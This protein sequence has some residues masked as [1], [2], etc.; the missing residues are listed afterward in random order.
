MVTK[1]FFRKVEEIYRE[2]EVELTSL[3]D[4][5]KNMIVLAERS[6]MKIDHSI[7]II[8]EM[9]K[10]VTFDSIADEICFFK[11]HK[12]LFVSK[13]IYYSKLL[14]IESNKPYAGIKAQRKYYENELLRIKKYYSGE[15]EFYN[16]YRRNAT[17]LDY[18]YFIRKAHDLKMKLSSNLYNFD[19]SFTTTH[20]HKIAVFVAYESL[21]KYL[22]H[23]LT[24]S[25]GNRVSEGSSQI[26]WTSSKVSLLELLYALHLSHC[27]NGGNIDF[28]EI[29]RHTEKTLDLNLGNVYKTIREIKNRKYK[30]N[31]FLELLNDNLEKIFEEDDH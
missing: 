31:R 1:A 24:D 4:N 6:L 18:K 3:A 22:T 25:S 15:Q 12:P 7:R 20:D 16:Y 23:C 27:F 5:E 2:L 21:E 26:H 30:R 28:I 10:Q 11:Q 17:Y 19:E 29:V 9:L 14:D 13:F 8:K